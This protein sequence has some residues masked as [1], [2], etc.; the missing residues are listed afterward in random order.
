MT[1]ILYSPDWGAGWSTWCGGDKEMVEYVLRYQPLIDALEADEDIGFRPNRIFAND[2]PYE[3]GSVLE[4]FHKDLIAKFGDEAG[5]MYLGGAR[6]LAV[7][8]VDGPFR[9]EEYD[10]NESIRHLNPERDYFDFED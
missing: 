7:A 8:E 10:G 6:D 5:M 2:P 1:K 4:Q 3:P 9:V